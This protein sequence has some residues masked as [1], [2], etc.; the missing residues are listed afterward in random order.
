[1]ISLQDL[2]VIT[3]LFKEMPL[4]ALVS[5]REAFTEEKLDKI[6]KKLNSE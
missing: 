5:F 1:M 2:E 4:R 3:S 6:L